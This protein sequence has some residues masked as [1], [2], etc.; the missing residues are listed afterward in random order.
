[1]GPQFTFKTYTTVKGAN[2]TVERET[3]E[4]GASG[5]PARS[6]PVNMPSSGAVPVLI[7]SGSCSE[8]LIFFFF[9]IFGHS[10]NILA[11]AKQVFSQ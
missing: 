9:L 1:M 6:H 7:E 10:L 11:L 3:M 2:G 5:R 4:V 8:L